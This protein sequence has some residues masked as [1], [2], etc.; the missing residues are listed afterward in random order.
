MPARVGLMMFFYWLPAIC[1][2]A[3][4]AAIHWLTSWSA[5]LDYTVFAA[6]IGASIFAVVVALSNSTMR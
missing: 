4:W 1:L 3:A 6:A 5:F 2:W